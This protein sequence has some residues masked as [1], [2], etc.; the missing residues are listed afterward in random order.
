[1]SIKADLSRCVLR[2]IKSLAAY[3]SLSK[4]RGV[5]ILVQSKPL[6]WLLLTE[7]S[8]GKATGLS[9]L[10]PILCLLEVKVQEKIVYSGSLRWLSLAE[11]EERE[12]GTSLWGTSAEH[13]CLQDMYM[14]RRRVWRARANTKMLVL[15]V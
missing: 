4:Q 3:C 12:P 8:P 11:E 7:P 2:K 14:A 10:L 13:G 6:C 15:E 9:P 1:M 5:S